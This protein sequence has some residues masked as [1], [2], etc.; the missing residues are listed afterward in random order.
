MKK[1]ILISIAFLLCV[2]LKAQSEGTIAAAAASSGITYSYQPK[3]VDKSNL[4]YYHNTPI[5]QNS[6]YKNISRILNDVSLP[7]DVL[8]DP[9]IVVETYVNISNSNANFDTEP[10]IAFSDYELAPNREKFF[11]LYLDIEKDDSNNLVINDDGYVRVGVSTKRYFPFDG[12]KNSTL[13][14]SS[15]YSMDLMCLFDPQKAEVFRVRLFVSAIHTFV[16]I[17]ASDV[18]AITDYNT[19]FPPK[20]TTPLTEYY[21]T[22]QNSGLNDSMFEHMNN[23]LSNTDD[24][25]IHLKHGTGLGVYYGVYLE[26]Y[27]D[28]KLNMSLGEG[29][30]PV[31]S[32]LNFENS[33]NNSMDLYLVVG[34]ANVEGDYDLGRRAGDYLIDNAFVYDSGNNA[35]PQV[36]SNYIDEGINRFSSIKSTN[37]KQGLSIGYTFAESLS[38]MMPSGKAVGLVMGGRT[39]MTIDELFN[40]DNDTG[41]LTSLLNDVTSAMN[42]KASHQSIN[43]KGIIYVP[44]NEDTSSDEYA[45]K[46]AGIATKLKESDFFPGDKLFIITDVPDSPDLSNAIH[47]F[48]NTS[49]GRNT[50]SVTSSSLSQEGICYTTNSMYELGQRLSER[51]QDG[52]SNF[53]II[54]NYGYGHSS[55]THFSDVANLVEDHKPNFIVTA[56]G[57]NYEYM[58]KQSNNAGSGVLQDD[59]TWFAT[60]ESDNSIDDNV[61]SKYAN[62]IYD[63]NATNENLYKYNGALR[64]I[65]RN[66]FYPALS[67][68]DFLDTEAS[69]VDLDNGSPDFDMEQEWLDYFPTEQYLRGDEH[70]DT[71]GGK[72]YDFVKGNIHFI[73]VNNNIDYH[74]KGNSG[75]S[76]LD[77][78]T[79]EELCSATGDWYGAVTCNQYYWLKEKLANSI[80]PYKIVVMGRPPYSSAT[81]KTPESVQMNLRLPF[82]DWGATM[83]ISGGSTIYERLRGPDGLTYVVNG[84]GG[85][86][87]FEVDDAIANRNEYS[88]YLNKHHEWGAMLVKEQRNNL[89]FEFYNTEENKRDWF[90]LF[91]DG[92]I[93]TNNSNHK[94]SNYS[95][96]AIVAS[97]VAGIAVTAIIGIIEY[98]NFKNL[99]EQSYNQVSQIEDDVMNNSGNNGNNDSLSESAEV[100]Q[101]EFMEQNRN[102]IEMTE[103]NNED[104]TLLNDNFTSKYD[105]D[106]LEY[107]S[108]STNM[109][110]ETYNNTADILE[111][112]YSETFTVNST[113]EEYQSITLDELMNEEFEDMLSIYTEEDFRLFKEHY[114]NNNGEP[115]NLRVKVDNGQALPK[116]N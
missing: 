67:T 53:S 15:K 80:A 110:V 100:N 84:L 69:F 11:E 55:N 57:D 6:G 16:A 20:E 34:G 116:C 108:S 70:E 17:S 68:S 37:L 60:Q 59:I 63:P 5:T 36:N 85:F 18:S 28:Y 90:E 86:P 32:G 89:L 54:G 29:W 109:F 12:E 72:Y 101:N 79:T 83:V 47:D 96:E 35:F 41:Y 44:S 82:K 13:I 64:T 9:M 87:D 81:T 62:Y 39:G 95:T 98:R 21:Y 73:V 103:T 52:V 31:Y 107:R 94:Q 43:F 45:E 75:V 58:I 30:S 106:L 26:H 111:T 88:K 114:F 77:A 91:D 33:K 104:I 46:L 25:R 42:L 7:Q 76:Q 40:D 22:S 61:G 3:I 66:R 99:K 97:V 113:L 8:D 49:F 24:G 74:N 1:I 102:E 14:S 71:E 78:R 93:K 92:T 23:F 56:G 27:E 48:A 51:I 10:I 105:S 4:V 112:K 19:T 65:R 115:S 2:Q 50:Y 38:N